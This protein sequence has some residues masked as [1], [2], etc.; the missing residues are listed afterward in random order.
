M[1]LFDMDIIWIVMIVELKTVTVVRGR[2]SGRRSSSMM[3]Y[4]IGTKFGV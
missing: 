3:I 1:N 2:R 4:S